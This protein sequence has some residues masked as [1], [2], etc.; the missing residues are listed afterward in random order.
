MSC[1]GMTLD[2]TSTLAPVAESKKEFAPF[3]RNLGP[4]QHLVGSAELL[5]NKRIKLPYSIISSCVFC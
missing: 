5:L 4:Q 1:C 2:S 3:S